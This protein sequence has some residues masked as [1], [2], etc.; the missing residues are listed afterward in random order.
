MCNESLIRLILRQIQCYFFVI[1]V[2][3]PD[4]V[5]LQRE[6]MAKAYLTNGYSQSIPNSEKLFFLYAKAGV[7]NYTSVTGSVGRECMDKIYVTQDKD[8]WWDSVTT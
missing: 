6:D 2:T 1:F 4:R 8:K 7:D 3:S 5:I